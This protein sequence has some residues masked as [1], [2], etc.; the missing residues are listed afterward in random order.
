MQANLD[1]IVA[2]LAFHVAVVAYFFEDNIS[3]PA[4]AIATSIMFFL[5]VI[6]IFTSDEAPTT[7]TAITAAADHQDPHQR[8]RRQVMPQETKP[9]TP[10]SN[11][12]AATAD[13]ER[14]RRQN[15]P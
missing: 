2:I 11:A 10:K 3:V 14:P 5:V 6:A 12:T 15:R 8:R 13:E 9:V 7:T 4:V 1:L